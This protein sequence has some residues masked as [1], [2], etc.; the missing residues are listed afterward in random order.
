ML[1]DVGLIESYL[2]AYCQKHGELYILWMQLHVILMESNLWTC[3]AWAALCIEEHDLDNKAGHAPR[4]V[5]DHLFTCACIRL[6][7][8]VETGC[9]PD[10]TYAFTKLLSISNS[11]TS[12]D[13][14]N[15]CRLADCAPKPKLIANVLFLLQMC[16]LIFAGRILFVVVFISR[17]ADSIW[18]A[19]IM[20]PRDMDARAR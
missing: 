10:S 18:S 1:F 16:L 12:L 4:L 8:S 17:L 19:S 20:N 2:N 6:W 3:T 15:L 5:W 13:C 14:E 11:N 9:V 7:V